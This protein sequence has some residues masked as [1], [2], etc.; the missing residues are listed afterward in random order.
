MTAERSDIAKPA[1]K[2]AAMR[3]NDAAAPATGEPWRGRR[4]LVLV[5]HPGTQG[6]QPK[7]TPL[8]IE[9][10][11]SAGVDVETAPWGRR[12]EG[13]SLLMKVFGR[14][15][16]LVHVLQRL[17]R[18]RFDV[19]LVKSAHDRRALLRD[20][21]LALLARPCVPCIVVQF[22]G[23]W[24]DKLVAPG[25]RTF[26][27]ASSLLQ[28]FTDGFLLLSREECRDW[29]RFRPRGRYL[30]FD[31]PFV[32]KHAAL[33]FSPRWKSQGGLPV[34][35]L[36]G[37]LMPEK[38]V[39][40][41]VEA[42]ALLRDRAPCQAHIAGNGPLK[43]AV[44]RRAAELGVQDRV[45]LLGYLEG[46][47]LADAYRAADVFAL[48]TYWGEGFATV[49]TEAMSMGLPVITTRIRGMADHLAE[50]ENALFVPP[51]DPVALAEAIAHVLS[52][53]DLRRR[54][55]EANRRKVLEFAPDQV[56]RRHL[57]AVAAIAGWT[58]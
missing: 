43:E 20:V 38:G 4:M 21:P 52:D 5:Q 48:P 53:A 37:R 49:L 27:A 57:V 26:K 6:P 31:N 3:A 32:E 18:D 42:I 8:L 58:R 47:S 1:P 55:S 36:V 40:E 34:V 19:L 17:R 41:L 46:D 11:R 28:R 35:L 33:P 2:A 44:A 15:V 9:G 25:H 7:H 13:E 54:M 56:T 24:P 51:R 16:D 50:Q 45:K 12:R 23:G 29:A 10:L 30:T 22:H 14:F 39:L